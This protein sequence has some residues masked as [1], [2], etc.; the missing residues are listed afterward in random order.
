MGAITSFYSGFK[1]VFTI[2]IRIQTL[3][4]GIPG[5]EGERKACHCLKSC[6]VWLIH[7][8]I[9]WIILG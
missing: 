3:E 6:S 1:L 7:A 5:K 4:N 2:A 8:R 9:A